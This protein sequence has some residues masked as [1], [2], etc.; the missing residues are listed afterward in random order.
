M[1]KLG[2]CVYSSIQNT[3]VRNSVVSKNKK[4]DKTL[5]RGNRL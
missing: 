4:I 5:V 3:R 1:N 2:N